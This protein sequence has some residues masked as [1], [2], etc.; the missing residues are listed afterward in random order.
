MYVGR[1]VNLYSDLTKLRHTDNLSVVV[2]ELETLNM[3]N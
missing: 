3:H 2:R 1:L